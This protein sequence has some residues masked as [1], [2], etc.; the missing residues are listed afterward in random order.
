[1]MTRRSSEHVYT[2]E[3]PG[4]LS[5]LEANQIGQVRRFRK[6]HVIYWQ[7]DPVEFVLVVRRGA[8]KVSSITADG[9][10]CT[11]GVLG[12]GALAG[13]ESY[14]LGKRHET[15]TE[16]L[17]DT[18]AIVILP[19][20]FR[21][22]LVIDS[23]FSL[24]VM[25]HLAKDVHVLTGRV[26]DFGLLDVH[27]RLKANLVELASDHGV[28]T[29][30][31]IKIDL[32]ITHEEI[33]EMLS[34]SRTT[35]T[36]ALGE[37]RRQGYLWKEGR[38][39]FLIPLEQIEILDNLDQAVVD[40]SEDEATRWALEAVTKGVDLHKSLEALTSGMRRV[41][42]MYARDEIDI[43]DII[44]AAYAMKS[45]VPIVEREI[46]RT[47]TLV[48]YQGRIVIGTVHGDIHDIGRI[49]VAMLLKARGFDVIDLGTDVPVAQF[50]AAVKQ[51]RPQIL[52][53]SSLMTST[54]QE[55]FKVIDA[56]T[57]AGLRDQIKVIV[58][59]SA[60]TRRL[61][62]QMKADG[63]DASGHGATEL[64]SRL[65]GITQSG[66]TADCE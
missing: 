49:V 27:Q 46:E 21:R 25:A 17:E 10:K 50:V 13:A 6:K 14:L 9:R 29:D 26:R 7:G 63:Y 4:L 62:E 3:D 57:D 55:P 31:G 53:M 52:A 30:K 42:R 1:M 58:G 2:Q 60:I 64:A 12:A 43:S 20:E 65:V 48:E 66:Q 11:Y 33:G 38:H 44:L 8:L 19:E 45:A 37:L 22:L 15:L 41:D 32:S 28:I 5:L 35:I 61:S 59:G 51:H 23:R 39:L 16:A 47:G 40:G 18:E 24:A 54:A 36:T 56:L 34:A